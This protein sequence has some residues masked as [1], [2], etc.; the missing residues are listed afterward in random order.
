M[1]ADEDGAWLPLADAD[2]VNQE[3]VAALLVT[4]VDDAFVSLLEAGVPIDLMPK[5]LAEVERVSRQNIAT[6]LASLRSDQQG[7]DDN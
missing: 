7:D 3:A 5:A 2:G 4:V 6:A 1:S